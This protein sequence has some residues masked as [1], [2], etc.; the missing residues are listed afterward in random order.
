MARTD[1]RLQNF[2]FAGR[3]AFAAA[4]AEGAGSVR[5][6][7]GVA[8]GGGLITDHPYLGPMVIDLAT[9]RFA[10][11][12]PALFDH[13]EAIGVI[14]AAVVGSDIKIDGKLFAAANMQAKKVVDMADAGMPWQFSVGVHP[15]MIDEVGRGKPVTVNGQKF[16]GPLSVFRNNRIRETSFCALGAATDTH[17][18]IFSVGGVPVADI[19]SQESPEMDQAQVD[20]AVKTA[21]DAAIAPLNASITAEKAR[22]DKAEADLKAANDAQKVRETAAR[23]DQVKALFKAIGLAFKDEDAKPYI[24]MTGDQFKAVDAQMRKRQ[25]IPGALFTE[26][27]TDEG[28]ADVDMSNVNAITL[29]AKKY[30]ADQ[31]ALGTTVSLSDACAYVGLRANIGHGAAL[32]PN[33]GSIASART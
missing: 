17:A 22:A 32:P 29:A 20:L 16:T 33:A 13:D 14:D 7:S 25:A 9:T 30:V 23:T 19:T 3:V 15:G 26:Q 28:S 21:V 11:P 27:A 6:F 31:K 2:E 8:Y 24:E 4:P 10:T 18:Q 5:K 1:K 12:A